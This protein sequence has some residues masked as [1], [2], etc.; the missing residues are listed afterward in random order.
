MLRAAELRE[1]KLKL[2]DHRATDKTGGTKG[3]FENLSKFLLKLHMRANKV[4]KRNS[5][6]T[7]HFSSPGTAISLQSIYLFTRA[8]FPAT[9]ALAG[10]SLVTTLPAPPITFPPMTA[11]TIPPPPHPI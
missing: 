9:M 4:K 7:C 1:R 5:I 10:T 11:S 8:G 6:F 3:V 2:L